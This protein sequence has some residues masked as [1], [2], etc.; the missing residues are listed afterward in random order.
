MDTESSG[1][2]F[3]GASAEKRA[4]LVPTMANFEDKRPR[5]EALTAP[6]PIERKDRY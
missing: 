3:H 6:D 5:I 4:S 2:V 1:S